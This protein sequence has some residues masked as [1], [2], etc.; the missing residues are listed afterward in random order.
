MKFQAIH[1]NGFVISE[2]ATGW[3]SFWNDILNISIHGEE[4]LWTFLLNKK[5]VSFDEMKE[6]C[7]EAHIAWKTK[8]ELTHKRIRVCIGATALP[9]NFHSV[10]V[11]K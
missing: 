7:K 2:R 11:K 10:W 3:A 8:K 4:S 9:S 6:A 1:P 5:P